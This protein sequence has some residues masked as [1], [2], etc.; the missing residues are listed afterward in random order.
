MF[1][2]TRNLISCSGDWL[3]EIRERVAL[4]VKVTKSELEGSRL[5]PHMALDCNLWTNTL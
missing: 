2:P 3:I 1:G 4:W 5:K